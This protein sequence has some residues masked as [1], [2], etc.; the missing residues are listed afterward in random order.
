MKIEDNIDF[1][2]QKGQQL[3]VIAPHHDD[4]ILGAGHFIL[5]AKQRGVLT[6][7]TE[8]I[9]CCSRTNF[10]ANYQAGLLS[11]E[12]ITEVT[13]ARIKEDIL[14]CHVLFNGW[15]NWRQA[16]AGEWDAPLR[17]YTGKKTEGG[18]A[19]GDFSMFR[20][21][22][23]NMFERLVA[24]FTPIIMSENTTILT[25]IANGK[26]VDHFTVREAL[27]RAAWLA[28]DKAKAQVVFVEDQP[29]TAGKPE[30]RN[31]EADKL[32]VR[33]QGSLK[34]YQLPAPLNQVGDKTLMHEI[35]N[36]HYRTQ[37][38]EDYEKDLLKNKDFRF[39]VLDKSAYGKLSK[40]VSCKDNYC[41]LSQY[42]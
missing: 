11:E 39:Y 36:A 18:G 16:I 14:G 20:T 17:L 27:L 9:T 21:E 34:A 29:Y 41:E 8:T 35:F 40:D 25:L 31:E 32:Q 28:S 38:S 42:C 2:L 26:H 33:A 24:K 4:T 3:V 13:H 7:T 10:F 22:E 6:S 19:W 37:W 5:E 15:K 12:Q 1:P 30:D 23:I